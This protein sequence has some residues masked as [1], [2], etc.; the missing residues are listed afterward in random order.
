MSDRVNISDISDKVAT[1]KKVSIKL[2]T[3]MLG[4][5]KILVD[6][7]NDLSEEIIH[8]LK[9]SDEK[10]S[11]VNRW[12]QNYTENL[13]STAKNIKNEIDNFVL[14]YNEGEEALENGINKY[15][16]LAEVWYGDTYG[17]S[18]VDGLD[19]LI[20]ELENDLLNVDETKIIEIACKQT[21]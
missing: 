15:S 21:F 19:L 16:N 13:M 8:N 10:L 1:L 7:E 6:D 14:A 18:G 5:M 17:K 4:I 20:I 11:E 2:L 9:L 3:K 12:L